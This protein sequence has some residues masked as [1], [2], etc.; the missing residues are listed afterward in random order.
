[1]W[2]LW[3]ILLLGNTVRRYESNCASCWCCTF[4]LTAIM[5]LSFENKLLL[6]SDIFI[7]F[8]QSTPLR[9]YELQKS[10]TLLHHTHRQIWNKFTDSLSSWN[11]FTTFSKQFFPESQQYCKLSPYSFLLIEKFCLSLSLSSS[12][13]PN[14]LILLWH[15]QTTC[16]AAQYL[17]FALSPLN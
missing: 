11:S 6:L 15:K 1:M 13:F 8:E 2:Q 10:S 12:L 4:P 17:F 5:K 7:I 16:F 9:I 14:N 3:N